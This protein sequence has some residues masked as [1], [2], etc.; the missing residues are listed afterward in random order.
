MLDVLSI[1]IGAISILQNVDNKQ[2]LNQ[3][4]ALLQ[5]ALAKIGDIHN[6]LAE[7]K[8]IHDQFEKFSAISLASEFMGIQR[9]RADTDIVVEH[10]ANVVS[11]SEAIITTREIKVVVRDG[12]DFRNYPIF[13][14]VVKLT[15]VYPELTS[16]L[17]EY[18]K[19]VDMLSELLKDRN[20]GTK[21]DIL[22]KMMEAQVVRVSANADETIL[23]IVPITQFLHY[24][25]RRYVSELQ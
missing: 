16:S 17:E 9:N 13:R 10:M 12:E 1:V 7:A 22:M 4:I 25:I 15:K 6:C 24:E 18:L 19:S 8:E 5:D 23:N 20:T 2:L 11:A 14:N 21:L 3:R